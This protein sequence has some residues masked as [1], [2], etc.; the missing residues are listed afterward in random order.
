[1]GN[2]EAPC[3]VARGLLRNFIPRISRNMRMISS[4]V[5]ALC[6]ARW[7][8]EPA[9]SSRQ[10]SVILGRIR[11]RRDVHLFLRR[12]NWQRNSSPSRPPPPPSQVTIYCDVV[13]LYKSYPQNIII[14]S[15]VFLCSFLYI[16]CNLSKSCDIQCEIRTI[17]L[18][19]YSSKNYN[20]II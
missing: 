1:M 16:S 11:G 3:T 20:R 5:R 13:H 7:S 18:S 9:H 2:L 6:S 15:H 12:Y 14:A 10:D 8:R 19:H 4:S 17:H